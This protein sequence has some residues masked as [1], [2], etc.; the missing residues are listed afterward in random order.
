MYERD[1]AEARAALGPSA[2][3]V[4]FAAGHAKGEDEVL[5]IGPRPR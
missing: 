1:L 3:A 5:S 2:F 4:H